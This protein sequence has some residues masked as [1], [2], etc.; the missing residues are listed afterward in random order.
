MARSITKRVFDIGLGVCFLLVLWFFVVT[1]FT[2]CGCEHATQSKSMND[3]K[4]LTLAFIQYTQ[5]YD[6]HF[7]GWVT[8]PDGRTAHNTWDAQLDP[9]IKSKDIFSGAAEG[10]GIRSYSDPNRTRVVGFGLNGLLITDPNAAAEGDADFSRPPAKPRTVGSIANP[11]D[12]IVFAELATT[13]PMPGIYGQPPNP[14]PTAGVPAASAGQAWNQAQNGWIDISPREFVENSPAPDCYTEGR[15]NDRSGVARSFYG[16]GGS[17]GFLDGHV[18]FLKLG[19]TVGL[20]DNVPAEKY[21]S[22][23]NAHNL[24]SPDK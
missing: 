19:Q 3:V 20:S 5:D 14:I 4:Q 24:W 22:P 7:P 23:D 8:N 10:P 1:P 17:Y 12:T 6:D 16:G 9:Q 13:E 15:W 21:W 2:S 18:K 11:S